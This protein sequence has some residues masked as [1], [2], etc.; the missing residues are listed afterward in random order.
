M[1]T[2]NWKL[3]NEKGRVAAY[4]RDPLH[5][6]SVN[7]SLTFASSGSESDVGV[8]ARRVMAIHELIGGEVEI[9]A[10]DLRESAAPNRSDSLLEAVWRES[11]D[12]LLLV[13]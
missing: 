13:T 5:S 1:R 3:A 4:L 10:W 11:H 6:K 2:G 7:E 9:S 8:L 12:E